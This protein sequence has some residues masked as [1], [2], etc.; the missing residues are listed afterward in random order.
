[1]NNHLRAYVIM[2]NDLRSLGAG[3]A[4]AHAHHAGTQMFHHVL[5]YGSAAHKRHFKSWLKQARGAGTTV[6]LE[7][8]DE[9]MKIA[10]SRAQAAGLISG[11][12]RDPA[13]PS[14][15]REGV[16]LVPMDVCAWF[17]GEAAQLK[18]ILEKF[19]LMSD[20][21]HSRG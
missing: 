14:T 21:W 6:V 13:F 15:T 9:S 2:R 7:G 4:A 10:V 19:P 1:M 12:W 17:F 11:V 18:P 5:E 3:K 20:A 8:C 16:F